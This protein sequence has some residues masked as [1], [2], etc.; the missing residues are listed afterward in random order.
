VNTTTPFTLLIDGACPLC[1][2][3]GRF[4]RWLDAGRGR[5]A[6]VDIAA[7]DFRPADYSATFD[8]LMGTIHG[9][10]PDG[11]LVTGMEAFRLAY[12]AAG[13]GW[14]L[15]WTGLPFLR[16]LADRA[17]AWFATHRLRLTGRRT[18]ASCDA[19]RCRVPA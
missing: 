3:E 18:A 7:P 6:L 2:K 11:S 5:L 9:V 16:P 19:G 12:R 10:R 15:A 13:H 8:Q 14:I 4:M 17:Y 1:A